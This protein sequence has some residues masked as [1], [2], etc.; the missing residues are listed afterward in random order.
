VFV[1]EGVDAGL[2]VVADEH[3]VLHACFSPSAQVVTLRIGGMF[4]LNRHE[5][6]NLCAKCR[7]AVWNPWVTP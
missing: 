3:H 7:A 6:I 1:R 4:G 5:R 2:R